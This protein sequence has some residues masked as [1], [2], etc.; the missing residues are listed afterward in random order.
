MGTPDELV[1]VFDAAGTR[2]GST[3]RADMRARSLWHATSSVLVRSGDGLRVYVHRRTETKDVFPGRF[4]CWAGGVLG[5]AEE[6]AACAR[7][8]LAEELGVS[9]TPLVR[10]FDDRY[11]SDTVRLFTTAFEARWDGPVRH[12]PEEVAEG[13]WMPLTELRDRIADPDWPMV[14]DGRVLAR[15]WLRRLDAGEFD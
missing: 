12:Q 13:G 15:R 3:S 5:A 14:P 2:V 7:R 11:E 8:E 1:A 4:D 10:L 6:M 9:G